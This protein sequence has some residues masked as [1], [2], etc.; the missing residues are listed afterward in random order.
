[1]GQGMGQMT[2]SYLLDSDILIYHINGQ[3]TP[4]AERFLVAIFRAPVYMSVITRMEVLGWQ[5][6]IDESWQITHDF[7]TALNEIGLDE[8][9]VQATVQLR[10]TVG[11]RLPD[12]IIAA[13]ALTRNLTLLT[14]NVEDFVRIPD[15]LVVNPFA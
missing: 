9:V 4:A 3:L 15:L 14:R 13:S 7:L 1:M 11:V 5:G 12:A 8:D 2:K 10:R 6:H